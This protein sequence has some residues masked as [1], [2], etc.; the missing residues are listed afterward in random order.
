[1]PTKVMPMKANCPHCSRSYKWKPQLA[2]RKARC[3]ACEKYF[4]VPQDPP[5]E[6]GSLEAAELTAPKAAKAPRP[7]AHDK[8]P[9]P[10]PAPS[11]GKRK[12]TD[13]AKSKLD[14]GDFQPYEIIEPE[15]DKRQKIT[16]KCSSCGKDIAQEAVICVHCGFN[17][18]TGQ[19]VNAKAPKKGLL[20]A[21]LVRWLVIG[22]LLLG[23]AGGGYYYLYMAN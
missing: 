17:R 16:E 18:A 4:V 6:E 23:A 7:A 15:Q 11:S 2:G 13:R 22:L 12:M 1:M 8:K 20:L 14:A 5:L 3:K 10:A 19:A 21:G 9:V